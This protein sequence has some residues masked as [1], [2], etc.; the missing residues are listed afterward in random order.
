MLP[1][2]ICVISPLNQILYHYT[3]L[4]QVHIFLSL[5]LKSIFCTLSN[6]LLCVKP[7]LLKFLCQKKQVSYKKKEH[8]HISYYAMIFP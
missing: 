7:H 2:I 6:V 8:K 3:V 4:T 1:L 5:I